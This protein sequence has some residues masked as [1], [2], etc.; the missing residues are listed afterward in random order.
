MWTPPKFKEV[1]IIGQTFSGVLVLFMAFMGKGPRKLIAVAVNGGVDTFILL[2]GKKP[3]LWFRG[4]FNHLLL[5]RHSAAT[6]SSSGLAL[7][8]Q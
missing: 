3:C 7:T 2:S 5:S 1:K 8:I 4:A 6:L